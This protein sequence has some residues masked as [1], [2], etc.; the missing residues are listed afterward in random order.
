MIEIISTSGFSDNAAPVIGPYPFTKLNTP[1]GNPASSIISANKIAQ[2]GDISLGFKTIVQ[3]AAIA[4]AT[5][6]HI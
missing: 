3:P 4:D 6:V 2:Y 5:F 1:L